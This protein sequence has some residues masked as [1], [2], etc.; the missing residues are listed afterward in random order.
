MKTM[1]KMITLPDSV[2]KAVE[3]FGKE[4][5]SK[6]ERGELVFVDWCDAADEKQVIIVKKEKVTTPVR[7]VGFYYDVVENHLVIVGHIFSDKWK[8]LTYIPLAWIQKIEVRADGRRERLIS[9]RSWSGHAHTR[10]VRFGRRSKAIHAKRV[11]A[12]LGR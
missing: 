10:K 12:V 8:D 4:V 9:N 2:R 1:D 3:N 11:K 6:L 7:T 5:A